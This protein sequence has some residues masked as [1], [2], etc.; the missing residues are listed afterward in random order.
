M[1]KRK[2]KRKLNKKL[3]A[4]LLAVTVLLML[5]VVAVFYRYGHIIFPKDP[6][7]HAQ[8][9]V[10]A[11][12][13]EKDYKRA[14]K[15]L[16]TAIKVARGNTPAIRE[17]KAKYCYDLGRAYLEW[18]KNGKELTQAERT[19]RLKKCRAYMLQS[20]SLNPTYKEPHK[21]LYDIHWQMAYG[22]LLRGQ[23]AVNWNDFIE[24]ADGLIGV[25]PENAEAYYRRGVAWGNRGEHTGDSAA[26]QRGLD[27]FK[28][29]ISLEEDNIRF[30]TARLVLLRRIESRNATVDVDAGF[31]EAFKANP[32]SATLRILYST[33][34]R[35]KNRSDEAERQIEEAI[36]REPE[37]P[38]GYIAM[39]RHL[40]SSKQY[41]AALQSLDAAEKKDPTLAQIYLQRS[42][43]HRVQSHMDKSVKTLQDGIAALEPKWKLTAESQPGSS[44]KRLLTEQM[45]RLNFSLGNV[46]LDHR[47]G[48]SDAEQRKALVEIARECLDKLSN[49]PSNSPHLAKLTGRLALV[50]N[51]REKAIKNLEFA[52]KAFRLSDLQTPALLIT[53]Y[54]ATGM[55]GKSERILLQLQNAP[56]LQDSVEV[57]LGLARLRIRNQD[58]EA[59]DNY[60]NRALRTNGQHK[61]ALQLKS[62]LHLLMGKNVSA[63][64]TKT[65]S[66]AGIKAMVEQA[67]L[68]WSDGQ[69]KE[70]LAIISKLRESLPK[71]PLLAER[72]VN[73]HLILGEK[74]K[75]AAV[76]QGILAAY[77]DNEALKF[78]ASLIDKTP[79]ERL[80]MQ[81]ERIDKSF[82]E[83]F[84]RVWAKTRLAARAG[85]REMYSKFLAEAVRLKPDAP[86][87]IALQFRTALHEKDWDTALKVVQRVEKKDSF[88]GKSMRAQMLIRRNEHTQAIAVLKPL[89]VEHPNSKFIL[90]SLGECYLATK[91]LPQ[92]EEVFGVLE[93]N[94]PGDIGALIGLAIVTQQQGRMADNE[95]YVLR[96]YRKAAG[97]RHSYISRRFLEIREAKA[98]G[99]E[100]TK[101]VQRREALHKL[102]PK[103]PNYLNNLARLAMLCEYRT[104][105]LVRAGELYREA[106]ENTGHSLQW[107]RTLAFFYARN[108]QSAK[109]EAVLKTGISEAQSPP[110]KIAWLVMHG[111][112]LTMYDRDQAMR[113]YDQASKL[114]P[115]NPLPFRAKA[116]L[117]AAVGR[118]T[119]AI[120]HMKA[121]VVKKPEDLKGRKALIQYRIKGRQYEKADKELEAF[122]AKNPNDAQALLLKAVLY[123]LSGRPA[124]AVAIATQA[125]KK[126]P[127][128][129]E[130]LS[131]R[132][133]AY[134]V[135]GELEMA[136]TDL[137]TARSLSKKP[138]IAME[139][140]DVYSR[141]GRDQDSTLV[142]KTVVAESKNFEPAVYK[143]INTYLRAKDWVNAESRLSEAKK[144]FPAEPR[145]LMIEAGM[146]QM[147]EQ[148]AKAIASLEQA[149]A[150]NRNLVT[151]AQAYLLG[152]LDG[153]HY[154][155]AQSVVESYK[156]KTLWSVW[157]NSIL[158]RIMVARQQTTKANELFG[159]AVEG[160]KHDE[161]PFVVS[162]IR[163]AYGPKVAIQRMVDWSKKQPGDWYIKVL[164]GDLCSAAV[165][166]PEAKITSAER[167]QYL[168]L[169][170]DSYGQAVT[171]AKQT[172]DVAMLSNRLG[173]VYYDMG[174]PREAE[175]AYKKCL[176][177]TPSD[178]AA[179]NNLAYLYVDDLNEPEKALP[180]VEKVIRL[181]P[182][183]PNV[184]DTYG[185]VMGR[186][187]R[188][189]KAKEFLQR[190]IERDPGLAA[191][192]FHLGWVFEQTGDRKQ[193]LTHYR[194]G[195]E[196]VRGAP[197]LPL[198]KRLQDALKR[199]GA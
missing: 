41:D 131:V 129:A 60:V 187:K 11:L 13:K 14:V 42:H 70:A 39:A 161:L 85:N 119:P 106:Y 71:N 20:I 126:H 97:R 115:S 30:W 120:E 19:D 88:Q 99:D 65:L 186:L 110:A 18:F 23:G 178:N 113:A 124:R 16:S 50:D 103:D 142:L 52:Y 105:D 54:D 188:Y 10:H 144:L 49:M 189:A 37:N 3:V 158:G 181:R 43:I 197:H 127:E 87:I 91:Q 75:A 117:Y 36:E 86:G 159:K 2:R 76:L 111:E 33:Y 138:Q 1:A 24:T 46:A 31:K 109:G 59:A 94:D 5:I 143:L 132:A 190:S 155:K 137:E 89:R 174:Q 145:Y 92:A 82:S 98:T 168:T 167:A 112:F 53:L 104:R 151:T 81:M 162:Q 136:K 77:P 26:T 108:G 15:E 163:E 55:P 9:G 180:Y 140:A 83:P 179:L 166:D 118:W 8:A 147:R 40:T 4:A 171:K 45:N 107:G 29:A 153:K 67:D 156:D 170:A 32:N 134:I 150:I 164:V 195:L 139:L 141:L 100:I 173:K 35:G 34:L 175:K 194:L 93:S 128:F 123:R 95:D 7:P 122:L 64:Q 25:D 133:R 68:R 27:D 125:I 183:D 38:Q 28:K 191:C 80:K 121:Y 78:Q 21:T 51:D 44:K 192:R 6:K 101:I 185:W 69:R 154:D 176:E 130:A 90:R 172:T 79:E 160:A 56:R 184:L 57:M 73:M 116:A 193:A 17:A 152:L 198:Y 157:M 199:L 169:A 62:E 74:D 22:Q 114:D 177:I 165:S 146:W 182:Q 84:P 48:T 148:N 61:A 12:D 102:G 58:Y 72:Q 196:L 96:A 66:N 63:E 47:R 149:L 135:L